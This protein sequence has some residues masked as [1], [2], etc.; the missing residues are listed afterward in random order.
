MTIAIGAP[1]V[2]GDT[3]FTQAWTWLN[4]EGPANASGIIDTVKIY[5][6]TGA[7]GDLVGCFVGIFYVVSGDTLKCRSAV[8]IGAVEGG[9]ERTFPG[10]SLAVEAGDFI[11]LYFS[12]GSIRY[13]N[14]AGAGLWHSNAEVNH[15]VVDDQFEYTPL[16]GTYQ[17]S[18]NGTGEEV[19]VGGGMGGPANLIAAG[20]I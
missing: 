10:L 17:L 4:K 15:C 5:A 8:E 3:Q 14:S 20:I 12:D 9:A 6:T 13:R 7:E 18:I 16:V 2:E 11:G 1:A 19:A